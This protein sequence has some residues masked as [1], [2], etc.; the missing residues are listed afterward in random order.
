[1]SAAWSDPSSTL[2]T[3]LALL[4]LGRMLAP[5]CGVRPVAVHRAPIQA[6]RV[7]YVQV[8]PMPVRPATRVRQCSLA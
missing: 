6:S 5:W 2:V 4:A 1:M 3:L 8:T 7:V